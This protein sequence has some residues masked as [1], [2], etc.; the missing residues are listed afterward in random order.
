MNEPSDRGP[1]GPAG[2]VARVERQRNPGAA[3]PYGKGDPGFRLRST[4]ATEATEASRRPAQPSGSAPEIDRRGALQ[5]MA[6]G[7]AVALGSCGRPAEKE[8]P[9]VNNPERPTPG[10][11]PPGSP[12]LAPAGFDR[13]GSG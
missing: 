4:R 5:L 2:P 3:S 1:A 9:S 10:I 11:R 13:G 6:S 7:A 8:V 12:T